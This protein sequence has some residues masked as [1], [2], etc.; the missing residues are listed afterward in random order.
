M[1]LQPVSQV[2]K[3]MLQTNQTFWKASNKTGLFRFFFKFDTTG[4]RVTQPS[5]S[6]HA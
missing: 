2:A 1:I 6:M 5:V 3:V 4:N